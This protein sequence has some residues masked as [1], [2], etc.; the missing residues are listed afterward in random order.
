[1]GNAS[2]TNHDLVINIAAVDKKLSGFGDYLEDVRRDIVE[3]AVVAT[4]AAAGGLPPLRFGQVAA[5]VGGWAGCEALLP[6]A[7]REAT[8]DMSTT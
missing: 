2:E 5:W 1:M 4:G 3:A 6:T 8:R 7:T